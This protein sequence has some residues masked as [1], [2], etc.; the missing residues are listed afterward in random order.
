LARHLAGEPIAATSPDGTR[1]HAEVFG[2]DGSPTIVLIHGWTEGIR[3]WA[4]VIPQ[5]TAR[6]LRVVAYDLRGH[7]RSGRPPGGDFSLARFG[8]DV[9]AVLAAA[10]GPAELTVVAGHSLGAMSIAAWAERHDVRARVSGAALLDTALGGVIAGNLVF[11]KPQLPVSVRE[12]I[13]RHLFLGSTAPIPDISSP[14]GH[15]MIRYF[16]FGPQA[17]PGQVAFYERMLIE[18]P[19]D[20][21]SGAGLAMMDMDLYQALERLTVPTLVVVGELDRLTPPAQA[22]RIA[23]ELPQLTELIVLPQTG[24]MGP[25]ERPAELSNALAELALNVSAA[26]VAA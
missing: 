18:C 14:I 16:A 22:R 25:L 6:G 4:Y 23:E 8:D 11:P 1:L 9:E 24:H 20:V 10:G 13:A 12:A 2:D 26:P 3:L 5:L 7:G 19:P 17:S 15:A 21:R